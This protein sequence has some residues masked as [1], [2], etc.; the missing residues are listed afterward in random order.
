MNSTKATLRNPK[1]LS[2]DGPPYATLDPKMKKVKTRNEVN[3][4][5]ENY[6]RVQPHSGSRQKR[7]IVERTQQVI[8]NK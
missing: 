8:E 5:T 1:G 7:I 6:G 4:T 3:L 2:F